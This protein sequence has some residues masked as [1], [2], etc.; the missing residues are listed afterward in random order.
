M[1][2]GPG[3][4]VAIVPGPCQ[5]A[6]AACPFLLLLL[7]PV[8]LASLFRCGQQPSKQRGPGSLCPMHLGPVERLNLR[9]AS[10]PLAITPLRPSGVWAAQLVAGAPAGLG[11]GRVQACLPAAH[12]LFWAWPN[13][14]N[15]PIDLAPE[16]WPARWALLLV[17]LVAWL[18]TPPPQRGMATERFFRAGPGGGGV[19]VGRA[20]MPR[21]QCRS[22]TAGSMWWA[23][24]L[25]A[26]IKATFC[27][28][29][30]RRK[31]VRPNA[32]RRGDGRQGGFR[33]GAVE[34][35]PGENPI[36]ASSCVDPS[37]PGGQRG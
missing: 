23:G 27:S 5:L 18:L 15:L 29:H 37:C 19:G 4:G 16:P 3:A 10:R 17:V 11:V 26:G 2:G 6:V 13:P 21:R 12:R 20:S 1:L 7:I 33:P 9:K 31:A 14:H 28:H 32:R 25:M 24:F 34:M 22:T 35:V 36:G 8:G 30:S